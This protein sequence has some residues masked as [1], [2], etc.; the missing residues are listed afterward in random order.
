MNSPL[1]QTL[2]QMI[3]DG[4]GYFVLLDPDKGSQE[5]LVSIARDCDTCGVDGLLI[6]GSYLQS[7]SLDPLIETIKK[8]VSIPVILFPGSRNQLSPHADGI[9]F[10]SLLSGRNPQYL[11]EEQVQAAPR[12]RS[13]GLQVIP[14]G[15]LLIESGSITDVETV[16]K[17]KPIPRDRVDIAVAHALAAEFL[18]MKLVYLEAGSGARNTVPDEM[19][20]AVRDAVSIP[21]VV[22]GGIRTPEEA[23][24]KVKAGGSFVVTGNILEQKDNTF[25]IRNFVRAIHSQAPVQGSPI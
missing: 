4:A 13:M 10:L 12:V 8:E 22:G 2:L 23:A 18:G 11:I 24:A 25:L 1:Y 16:S 6:G 15:Y 9:L 17:T 14:T 3:Q 19:I 21:I 20:Q 5:E 7:D